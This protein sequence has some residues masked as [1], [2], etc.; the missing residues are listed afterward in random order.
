MARYKPYSY[1][2]G[3]F[4]PVYFD[5]QIQPGTFE[6]TLHH[7]IDN[8][9]DLSIF[10]DRFKNDETG[11]PAYDPKILLKI[12]LF[13]YSRGI[14]SSRK[15]AQAC[16]E[17]V[18][19]MALSADTRPH[20]TTIA[21]FIA[22]LDKEI[23][24]LFLEVLL[25]CDE[26]ELIGREMFA[27]DGCKLPS[28]ASK[29]WS[30]TRAG[31]KK[32]AAKM[33]KAIGRMLEK[34]RAN[35]HS[36]TD[37]EIVA[38]EK[39]YVETLGKQVKKIREWLS[40]N[41]DK[42]GKGGKPIQS[43]ITDNESAKMKTSKGVIQGYDGVTTVDGKNQVIVH[44]EAFGQAQEH[45]LLEPMVEGTRD[46]FQT[47]GDEN[48]FE[49][50]KLTADSGF[51]TEDNMKMLFTGEIDAYVADKLFRKRDSVDVDEYRELIE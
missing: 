6:Y 12:I 10:N 43:N 9:L 23:V 35:D 13:A 14:V 28:N 24:K 34:H 39:K 16:Q 1:A 32:K 49:E 47:L 21:D 51:H 44:A 7:L 42:M 22:S 8:E 11:A 40:N 2:Q 27:I 4:I 41:D 5:K 36:P 50:A 37:K 38:K 45:D 29:E 15:I 17:N 30:N 46:N 18:V 33:E 31:F 26:Q 25:V 48:V 20:F 3:K 19:F